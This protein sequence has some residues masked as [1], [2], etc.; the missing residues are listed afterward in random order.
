VI[1][2]LTEADG[3]IGAIPPAGIQA[4]NCLS[5]GGPDDMES[6]VSIIYVLVETRTPRFVVQVVGIAVVKIMFVL[7][8]YLL[9]K[10]PIT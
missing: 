8:R 7:A 2:A 6:C 4:L 10:S 1:I 3:G 5:L 9:S